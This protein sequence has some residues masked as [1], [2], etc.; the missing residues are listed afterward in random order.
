M[1]LL[2][3]GTPQNSIGNQLGPKLEKADPSIKPGYSGPLRLGGSLELQQPVAYT[4]NR[5]VW[6]YVGLLVF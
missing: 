2:Q 6:V 3:Q 4:L 5:L 1:L